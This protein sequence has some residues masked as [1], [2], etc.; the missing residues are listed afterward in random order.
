[1]DLS[2]YDTIEGGRKFDI[3][4]KKPGKNLEKKFNIYNHAHR[5]SLSGQTEAAIVLSEKILVKYP[6]DRIAIWLFSF[7][8][9][10]L[11]DYKSAKKYYSKAL[12]H[13]P[14]DQAL[15]NNFLILV[16]EESPREALIEFL[17]LDRVFTLVMMF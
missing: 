8:Y 15:I 17:K 16:G 7:S 5:A 13:Y 9:H 2:G 12:M 10:K 4:I 3:T 14:D 6:K 1:M 11:G